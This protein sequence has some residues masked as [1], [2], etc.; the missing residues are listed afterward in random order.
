MVLIAVRNTLLISQW[1]FSP[2]DKWCLYFDRSQVRIRPV[3][4]TR[5]L[6]TKSS[7]SRTSS[8]RSKSNQSQFGR[9]TGSEQRT[10][11]WPSVSVPGGGR[12]PAEL[13]RPDQQKHKTFDLLTCC[14]FF[15]VYTSP[16]S[17]SPRCL[18][19]R[20]DRGNEFNEVIVIDCNW[21]SVQSGLASHIPSG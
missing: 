9:K 1:L 20:S 18:A 2:S 21:F 6:F 15:F 3:G 8:N 4:K 17:Q 16:Q 13:S 11:K 10:C 5:S 14:S 7:Q 19:P 12:G